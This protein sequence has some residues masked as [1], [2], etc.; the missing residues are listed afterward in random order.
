ML[1]RVPEKLLRLHIQGAA[2]G[3]K[4]VIEVSCIISKH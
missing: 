3:K 1:L 2:A 4:I